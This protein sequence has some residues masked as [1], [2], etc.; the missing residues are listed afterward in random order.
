MRSSFP[1]NAVFAALAIVATTATTAA[2]QITPGSTLTFTGTANAT[3]VGLPG[4]ILDFNPRVT[5][6]PSGNT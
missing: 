4:V 1:T 5:A 2:A 3:D 6:G